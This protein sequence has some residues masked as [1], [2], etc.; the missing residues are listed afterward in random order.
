M[1]NFAG[2]F[3]ETD[4]EAGEIAGTQG[5]GLVDLRTHD[6]DAGDISLKLHEEVINGGAA[7]NAKFF[8][9][10]A[11]VSFHRVE[12][13][14]RLEGDAFERG[15]GDVTGVGAAG[16]AE[17]CAAGG[18]V[19]MRFGSYGYNNSNV[20][21]LSRWDLGEGQ[22]LGEGRGRYLG[23]SE[24]AV[25]APS[26]MIVLG[27]SQF[28]WWVNPRP[29]GAFFLSQGLGTQWGNASQKQKTEV[30]SETARRHR[31]RFQLAF[32]DGHIEAI[33]SA[34]IYSDEM[35]RRW[36]YDNQPHLEAK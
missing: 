29:Q 19:P 20:G 25:V 8:Y 21:L 3:P 1:L 4:A 15:P 16:D 6:R 34:R 10:Y 5:G 32:C 17:N 9:F 7:I 36:C 12:D 22:N 28:V 24:S 30:R 18:L 31:S 35:R 23:R 14:H 33:D 27:D 13:I 2:I 26:E 11:G